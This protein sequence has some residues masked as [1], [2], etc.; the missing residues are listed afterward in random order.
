MF[1]GAR[2]DAWDDARDAE[3]LCIG[4]TG[5]VGDGNGGGRS[6]EGT[7]RAGTLRLDCWEPGLEG[8]PELRF[9]TRTEVGKFARLD[10]VWSSFVPDVFG[11]DTPSAEGRGPRFCFDLVEATTSSV[12]LLMLLDSAAERCWDCRTG[13]YSFGIGRRTSSSDSESM[14]GSEKSIEGLI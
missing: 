9:E 5:I 2:E 3:G 4:A 7:N 12:H 13:T 11:R 8:W 1:S 6:E 14:A 10:T